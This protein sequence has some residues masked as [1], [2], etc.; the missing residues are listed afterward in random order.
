MIIVLTL[1]EASPFSPPSLLHHHHLLL[2]LLIC[3]L[4]P[5]LPSLPIGPCVIFCAAI[6]RFR[7]LLTTILRLSLLTTRMEAE[8]EA[9]AEAN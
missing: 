2:L 1:L 5:L 9:G 3:I 7:R 6:N 8:A 4:L